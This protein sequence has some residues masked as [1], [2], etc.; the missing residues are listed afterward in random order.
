MA[1]ENSKAPTHRAYVVEERG[2]DKKAKWH[3]VGACWPH[4]DGEGFDFVIPPGLSVSGRVTFRLNVP[5]D[6]ETTGS[7]PGN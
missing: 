6:S 1:Q 3:D 5:K 2:E 7:T 4:G